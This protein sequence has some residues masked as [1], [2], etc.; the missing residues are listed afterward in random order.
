MKTL[1]LLLLGSALLATSAFAGVNI[2]INPFEIAQM[3]HAATQSMPGQVYQSKPVTTPASKKKRTASSS[4]RAPSTAAT[5]SPTPSAED[6]ADQHEW[7]Q[8]QGRLLAK[9]GGA[10]VPTHAVFQLGSYSY[11]IDGG[12]STTAYGGE[13]DRVQSSQGALYVVVKFRIRNDGNE[14]AVTDA[15]DFRLVDADGREFSPDSH[16]MVSASPDFL[17]R[18]LHPGIWKKA[19]VIFEVPKEI[20]YR[21]VAI[22]IPEKGFG[23][24]R[25]I[26]FARWTQKPEHPKSRQEI[27]SHSTIVPHENQEAKNDGSI[28]LA[29]INASNQSSAVGSTSS[30]SSVGN[31][32]ESPTQPAGIAAASTPADS[33]NAAEIAT[34]ALESAPAATP[35]ASAISWEEVNAIYNLRSNYTDL[36]KE[37]AWKRFKGQRV[38]WTGKVEGIDKGW[39][40][41]LHLQVKMNRDTFTFDLAIDLKKSEEAKAMRIH[42]GDIIRFTGILNTWGS[43]LPISVD[44]GEII[45]IGGK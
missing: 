27:A 7:G 41:G 8:I 26:V 44:D 40:G 11:Q 23:P 22:V 13:F 34:T 19:I 42:K 29:T 32:N 45:S 25:R 43:L 28:T 39:L 16:A 36:Q 35:P 17:L 21:G 5:A 24:E 30:K 20:I 37:E 3:I 31:V 14:T 1:M 4:S 33:S 38:M 6:V 18:E 15:N 12:F 9:I 10:E 2:Q